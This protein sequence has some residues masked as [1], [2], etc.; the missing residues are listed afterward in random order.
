MYIFILFFIIIISFH[1]VRRL[2]KNLRPTSPRGFE[3]KTCFFIEI[4]HLIQTLSSESR[5]PEYG[6]EGNTILGVRPY[7]AANKIWYKSLKGR[8]W[9]SKREGMISNGNQPPQT[10]PATLWNHPIGLMSHATIS[11]NSYKRK[12]YNIFTALHA[13]RTKAAKPIDK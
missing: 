3:M 4:S 7:Q 6:A 2:L 9:A 8:A 1:I 10:T 12:K 13:G 5:V 11:E